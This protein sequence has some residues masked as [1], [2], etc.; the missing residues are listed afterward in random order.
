MARYSATRPEREPGLRPTLF[1][2]VV[3]LL[4]L[5][6]PGTAVGSPHRLIQHGGYVVTRNGNIV[7]RRNASRP[8]IPAST[9]KLATSLAALHF[10]GPDYR[11]STRFYL[12]SNQ[13]LIIE[14]GGDPFLVGESI[15]DIAKELHRQGLNAIRN[16]ILDDSAFQLS[17]NADGAGSSTNP[18]DAPNGALAVNFN[19]LPLLVHQNGT[20]QSAEPQTPFIPLMKEAGTPLPHGQ[21]RINIGSLPKKTGLSLPLRYV[22]ELFTALFRQEGIVATGT[23][24]KG[25]VT[26]TSRLMYTYQ[27][28]KTVQELIEA[29]L[30]FSNNFIA[31]QLFLACGMQQKGRPAT[32]EK[33]R[34]VV[35]HYL[36]TTLKLNNDQLTLVEGSGL[37][38]KNRITPMAMIRLLDHFKPY[39][40][41]LPLHQQTP[42]KTG[43]LSGVFCLVG[44]FQQNGHPDPF[45][46]FLNQKKNNRDQLFQTLYH[47]YLN[48]Q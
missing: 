38:R 42:V 18:Y 22:G 3:L 41:L 36:R 27:S 34:T 2:A 1:R 37:S 24:R 13:D 23:I 7:A 43:T 44:Y 46:I 35:L 48:S 19:S 17:G 15:A 32:W 8:F 45:V 29:N 12:D 26:D 21:Y 20:I 5:A 10:L 47:H 9:I 28:G 16:I 25:P 4:L 31:N 39:R 33:A 11:F 40:H 14:G 30:R 6:L